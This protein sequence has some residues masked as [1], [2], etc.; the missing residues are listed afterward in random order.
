M[1]LCGRRC[2]RVYIL[3]L[4]PFQIP[5]RYTRRVAATF[6]WD[7]TL[8]L[9]S[10]SRIMAT[11]L[12]LRPP[13]FRRTV[14][15]VYDDSGLRGFY[16]GIGTSLLRAF[17]ANA[18]ALFVYEGLMRTLGAEK[19]RNILYTSPLVTIREAAPALSLTHWT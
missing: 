4:F 19:V 6:F 11:P 1:C 10:Q 9:K 17:P 16:R 2:H 15:H 5:C 7:S 14:C 8:D 3:T 18:C 12:S 13:S